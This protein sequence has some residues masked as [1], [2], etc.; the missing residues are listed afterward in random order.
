[1][2][3]DLLQ[4]TTVNFHPSGNWFLVRMNLREIGVSRGR[5]DSVYW[6]SDFFSPDSEEDDD[7][8]SLSAAI[9]L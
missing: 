8:V 5:R 3:F 9:F 4:N 6:E 2:P 1:M 7:D